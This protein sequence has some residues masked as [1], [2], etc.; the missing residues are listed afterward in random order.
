MFSINIQRQIALIG[1]KILYN[2]FR[3]KDLIKCSL[4]IIRIYKLYECT[5]KNIL[6][7]MNNAW[8]NV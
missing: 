2:L 3:N 7:N 5:I 8:A 6:H 1:N 4:S